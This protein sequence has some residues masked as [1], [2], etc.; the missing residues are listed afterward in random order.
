MSTGRKRT[1]RVKVRPRIDA[2]SLERKYPVSI[3]L[4]GSEVIAIEAMADARG[5]SRSEMIRELAVS[6]MGSI[7]SDQQVA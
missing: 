3:A 7:R 6:A 1:V 4:L 5:I 2:P